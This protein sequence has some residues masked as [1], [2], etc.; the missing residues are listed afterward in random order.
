MEKLIELNQEQI[1]DLA[2]SD[3]YGALNG[4]EE[5]LQKYIYA[6]KLEHYAKTMQEALK[7]EALNERSLHSDKTLNMYGAVSSVGETG[8]R[9]DFSKNEDVKQLE[10]TLKSLKAMLKRS[11]M[12]DGVMTDEDGTIIPKVPVKTYSTTVLKV[13][14]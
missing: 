6:K 10:D 9:Y 4:E 8:I 7:E 2:L 13:S 1:T 5:A 3:C 11:S 14:F 12:H